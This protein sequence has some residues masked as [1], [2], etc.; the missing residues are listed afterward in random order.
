[1]KAMSKYIYIYIIITIIIMFVNTVLKIYKS[2]L[3]D[4]NKCNLSEKM[5]V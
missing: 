3:I 2:M 1:M 4:F 5:Y